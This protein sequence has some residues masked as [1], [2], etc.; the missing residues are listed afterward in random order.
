MKKWAR[1]P[2][3]RW[4]GDLKDPSNRNTEWKTDLLATFHETGN[5]YT[6]K[7]R[8]EETKQ[9]LGL[10]DKLHIQFNDFEDRYDMATVAERETL[11]AIC[12]KTIERIKG[13]NLKKKSEITH[14]FAHHP[15]CVK[16]STEGYLRG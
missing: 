10:F 16:C 1:Y 14:V 6:D 8:I 12:N 13:T 5:W 2:I 4:D 3:R 7:P 11:C 15:L 9:Y